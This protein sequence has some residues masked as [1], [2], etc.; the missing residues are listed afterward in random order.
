[1]TIADVLMKFQLKERTPGGS[2]QGINVTRKNNVIG[3][4]FHISLFDNSFQLENEHRHKCYDINIDSASV[5]TQEKFSTSSTYAKAVQFSCCCRLDQ[6]ILLT[7]LGTIH[8]N[9]TQAPKSWNCR[10]VTVATATPIDTTVSAR[11]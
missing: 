4:V 1:M 10:S 3:V 8:A 7:A 2:N 6:R 5:T 9:A 11:T